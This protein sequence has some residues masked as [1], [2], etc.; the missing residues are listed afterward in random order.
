[1]IFK[2]LNRKLKNKHSKLQ[3]NS[4]PPELV[5]DTRD[6]LCVTVKRHEHHLIWKSCWTPLCVN[7]YK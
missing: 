2:T 4:V 1:M 6:T 3:A 5:A 7:K